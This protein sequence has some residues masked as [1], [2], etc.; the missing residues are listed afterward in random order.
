VAKNRWWSAREI[1]ERWNVSER[2]V[3]RKIERG[4]LDAVRISPRV[5]RV[6]WRA[7]HRY[8]REHEIRPASGAA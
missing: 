7:L 1:A 5:V 8:E 4:E 2:S 6:S 3:Q